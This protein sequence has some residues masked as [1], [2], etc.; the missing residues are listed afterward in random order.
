M[1]S[2]NSPKM[3]KFHHMDIWNREMSDVVSRESQALI[4]SEQEQPL[5]V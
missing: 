5:S 1:L 4:E 2:K 3:Y